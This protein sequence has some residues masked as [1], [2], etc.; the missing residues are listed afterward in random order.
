VGHT[1][2][3]SAAV[4]AIEAVDQCVGKVITAVKEAKGIAMVTSDHGNAEMMIDPNNGETFTAHTTNRVPFALIT[5]DFKGGLRSD[6]RLADVAP[7]IL[8]LMDIKK[9]EEM[10][11]RNLKT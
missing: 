9:P 7:T 8:Y 5:D 11:G 4:K 2:F 10:E 6:G 1:G 3:L